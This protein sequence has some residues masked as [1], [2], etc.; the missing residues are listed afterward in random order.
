MTESS[1][2][3]THPTP[4]HYPVTAAPSLA[5]PLPNG[6]PSDTNF[7]DEEEYTIKCICIY[8]DDD[9]NTVYCP[10]C[11]TWQ[12][13]EC[14]YHGKKVPEEHFCADCFPRD[15]DAKK[16][17]ERQRRHREALDGGDRKVKR[18]TSKSQKKKHKDASATTEQVNGWHHDRH[19]S[20][21]SARDGPPAKKPKTSHRTSGSVIST[22]GETRKRA[23][24]TVQSYP[25]P[26][27][28]PQDLFRFPAIP[29]Y[30]TDFLELYER[31][32][33]NTNARDNEQTIQA[34]NT[35]FAWRTDPSL[36]VSS[37]GQQPTAKSPFVRANHG[38]DQ[39]TWPEVAVETIHKKDVEYEGRSPTW[40]FLRVQS[41]VKKD[42]IVGEV[43]GQVGTLE[44]YCQQKSSSNRWQELRHPDPFV[45]FHPHMDI[46]IDSRKSGTR[47][48]YLRRSCR[49]NVTLKTF[50]SD[51]ETRH[52]FVASKDIPAG[53]ELTTMWFLDSAMF[54]TDDSEQGQTRRLDWVSRVLANF[55]D[56][57]CDAG[58]ACLLAPF[59][60]RYPAKP[61][62]SAPKE[63]GGRKKKS[64][65]NHT[66]SPFSTG[67]ATN[68]RA[69]SE[70]KV[71]D[72]EDQFDR[73]STSESSRSGML[74][75]DI[76][77][78]NVAAL[79]ADPV[80]GNGLTARELRKIQM[81]EK[82][83]AQRE[84]EKKDQSGQGQQRK[85]KRTS[86]GSTLNT[87]NVNASKPLGHQLTSHPHTPNNQPL[88]YNDASL[89]S[90]PPARGS[91]GRGKSMDA[92]G[93]M[94]TRIQR[95]VYVS[96]AVQTDPEELEM[97][98]PR[99]AKRR[100][101]CTPT[102]R[103]LRRLLED[104][105]EHG[106]QCPPQG[107]P[108]S[109]SSHHTLER[110]SKTEDVEMKDASESVDARSVVSAEPDGQSPPGS[111]SPVNVGATTYPLPSQAAHTFKAFSR[112]SPAPKLHLSTLPPVPAFPTSA[113]SAS[114]SSTTV[115]T[116]GL[117]TSATA[118]SPIPS[119]S[120]S[121]SSYPAMINAAVTPS[122]ARKKLSLGDYMSRRLASTPSA[123][124][125]QVQAILGTGEAEPS[126]ALA[127]ARQQSPGTVESAPGN[128]RPAEASAQQTPPEAGIS[129]G[130]VKDTPMTEAEEPAYSPPD[131]LAVAPK[132]SSSP[133]KMASAAPSANETINIPREMSNVLA[134]LAQ[135]TNDSRGVR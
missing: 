69:G 66:I 7:Q 49:P 65:M 78:V 124:K 17:T 16:A 103:L 56:C 90:P 29:T 43:R 126:K 72:D 115:T 119:N 55:G 19:E 59:D 3:T 75:R 83:F 105:A 128:A 31:D 122:P 127:E 104:R 92:P 32:E 82:A 106:Q 134:Q 113:T 33:G 39:S 44:E 58:Q 101:F 35:L 112:S 18:P 37:P 41:S 97:P 109:A 53:A 38:L 2:L 57:A 114:S 84:Q 14:Y 73:R 133:P 10:K 135:F 67:H 13:I 52:C 120:A 34:T 54:I 80:L 132:P 12:H 46:Y 125:S 4:T 8:A 9:G 15:L 86:G 50:V 93:R 85:K 111:S 131:V 102:Q 5:S 74:S 11:D 95:P 130:A 87:P 64:K 77:P 118:H 100:R 1:L 71:L 23:T 79:D 91:A 30:T 47:F 70:P 63:K 94:E 6:S 61:V 28:S 62:E 110:P 123:E 60:R 22:N 45:F 26:S 40:R 96:V 108:A 121:S 24:S 107:M 36:V 68:S 99:P 117:T 27:K 21:A 81:A 129:S 116:P 89:G 48:R 76:T 20:V 25:S 42:E 88:K 98:M 51:N